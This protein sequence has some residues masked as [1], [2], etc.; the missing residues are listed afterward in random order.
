MKTATTVAQMLIRVCGLILIILGLVLWFGNADGLKPIHLL[1]GFILVFSLWTLAGLA[2][3]AG[4]QLGLVIL[5]VVWGFVAPIL[6]LIQ[7]GLIPGSAHW[8]IQVVHLLVGLVAIG[9]GE[10]L[11][12][13]IKRRNAL[14]SSRPAGVARRA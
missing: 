9:L 8:V 11:G 3:R 4:V 14:P 13:Q 10:M 1:F 12:A 2:A 7:E 5:A 6:G